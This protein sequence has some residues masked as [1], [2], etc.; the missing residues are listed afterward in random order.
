MVQASDSFVFMDE[1]QRKAGEEIAK[2]TG[3]EAAYIVSG[4]AAGL[5]MS[6]AACIS[7]GDTVLASKLPG[8]AGLRCEVV[9]QEPHR[10][11]YTSLIG[12]AGGKARYIGGSDRVTEKEL[13]AAICDKTAA[14]LHIDF[15]PMKGVVPLEKVLEMA[16]KHN[17][18]VVV[19]AAAELPPPENL[20]RYISIGADLVIFSGGKDIGAPSDSGFVCGRKALV[21]ACAALGPLNSAT[22]NGSRVYFLGRPMKTSKEDVAA[23]VVALRTYVRRSEMDSRRRRRVTAL[24]LKGLSSIPDVQVSM[25]KPGPED[26]IRPLAIP[27]VKVVRKSLATPVKD[28]LDILER[29][30]PPIRLYSVGDALYINPQ[31]LRET[32]VPVIV[33]RLRK[34][35]NNKSSSQ[36]VGLRAGKLKPVRRR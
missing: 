33:E 7:R 34:V 11:I 14:V 31:C 9:V 28:L 4:S 12:F 29:G 20:F 23:L 15:D 24:L 30:D 26:S 2:I 25:V 19:D 18:P 5:V 17:V 21:D 1:L 13:E 6:V 10:S 22:I 8:D 32:D 35:L 27:R 3:A 16:H 36:S